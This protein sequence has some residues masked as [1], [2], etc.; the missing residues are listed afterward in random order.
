MISR[1]NPSAETH[2]ADAAWSPDG[3]TASAPTYAEKGMEESRQ[4][5]RKISGA[6][7]SYWP[8]TVLPI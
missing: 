5:D 8:L 1:T 4:A 2:L 3:G 6:C 7:S